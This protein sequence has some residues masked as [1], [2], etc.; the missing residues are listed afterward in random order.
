MLSLSWVHPLSKLADFCWNSYLSLQYDIREPQGWSILWLCRNE[1]NP[2]S[3]RSRIMY[4]CHRSKEIV[5]L[6]LLFPDQD[7]SAPYC[8]QHSTTVDE[9]SYRQNGTYVANLWECLLSTRWVGKQN[10]MK[11]QFHKTHEKQIDWILVVNDGKPL[12]VISVL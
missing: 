9:T 11:S 10:R 2:L 3:D 5:S 8:W 7:T 6:T 1:I 12:I 4:Y